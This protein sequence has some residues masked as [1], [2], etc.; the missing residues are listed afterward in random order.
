MGL[1]LLNQDIISVML[2]RLEK[3][4]KLPTTVT[5]NK[6]I[7]LLDYDT[8]GVSTYIPG[9][10]AGVCGA[11]SSTW[12]YIDPEAPFGSSSIGSTGFIK[13]TRVLTSTEATN[14]VMLLGQEPVDVTLVFMS[15]SGAPPQ[16]Q[17]EDFGSRLG[18]PQSVEWGDVTGGTT[19]TGSTAYRLKDVLV[20]GDLI[21]LVYAI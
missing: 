10:Y 21:E 4:M 18:S 7:Q 9:F 15:I 5:G 16:I 2:P 12:V 19:V 1:V 20:A 6:I 17:G 8:I 3:Y 13:E 11:T 14:N